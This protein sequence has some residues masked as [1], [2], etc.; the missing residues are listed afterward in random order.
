MPVPQDG[1]LTNSAIIDTLTADGKHLRIH[2]SAEN[3][4][5]TDLNT[6]GVLSIASPD[7]H[8]CVGQEKE[9]AVSCGA[10]GLLLLP[11][12]AVGSFHNIVVRCSCGTYNKF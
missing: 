2:P 8:L 7:G 6:T 4:Y 11:G 1:E 3:H 10:C 12:V 5:G 9:P